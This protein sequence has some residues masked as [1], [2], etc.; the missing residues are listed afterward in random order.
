MN[1]INFQILNKAAPE[2]SILGYFR[3]NESSFYRKVFYNCTDITYL[4]ANLKSPT[5][6]QMKKTEVSRRSFIK[7]ASLLAAATPLMSAELFAK[8]TA[9]DIPFPK[10]HIFS[11]HLQFLDYDAMSEVAKEIGFDG[12]DLTVRPKGHVLP[13]RVDDDLPKAVEAMKKVGI[14][15]SLFC[16]AVE[17]AVNT[18]DVRLLE[19]ASKLGF[20]YYRM[21][22]Y[23]YP[24]GQTMPAALSRL[25]EQ[26]GGLARLNS[27][28]KLVG[29]YQNHAGRLIGSSLWE[30]HELLEKA[31]EQSM[32]AQYDIR[33]AVVEGGLSWQNGLNLIL[34]RIKTIVLKDTMW[35]NRTG[36]WG[37]QNVPLGQGMVDWGTYFKILKQNKIQVP[38]C[39]HLEYPIG[40][41]E[42][43]AERLTTDPNTVYEAMKRDLATARELWER[44]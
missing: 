30:V 34:P 3:Y 38:F 12:I 24:E 25:S 20:E 26:I 18:T 13:E 42:K 6:L 31:D 8:R 5:Q 27:R 29:C 32:G 23:R 35:S 21:N 1:K 10:I 4:N 9:S 36:K 11:K 28:L 14:E 15:P 40:G 19:A 44:A 16:T 39:L 17:S 22:W 33:H 43:G 41:A 7:K 37:V 2:S